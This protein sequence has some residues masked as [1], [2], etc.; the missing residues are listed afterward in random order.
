MRERIPTVLARNLN[1]RLTPEQH[2]TIDA[3]MTLGGGTMFP[4]RARGGSRIHS[5]AGI[6]RAQAVY[7]TARFNNAGPTAIG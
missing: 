5:K 2:E 1:M 3:G 7:P 6:S 4:R